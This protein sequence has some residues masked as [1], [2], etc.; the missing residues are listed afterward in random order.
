M[1]SYV[2][3]GPNF[4]ISCRKGIVWCQIAVVHT[5]LRTKDWF[6][7]F[8]F[9]HWYWYGNLITLWKQRD[10]KVSVTDAVVRVEKENANIPTHFVRMGK[11]LYTP[12]FGHYT[13][14]KLNA[15]IYE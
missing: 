10:I 2:G 13:L 6:Y 7:S 1:Q 4:M 15:H 9:P 3:N 5:L 12:T 8:T 14:Y 11:P